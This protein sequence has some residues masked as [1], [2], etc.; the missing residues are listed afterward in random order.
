MNHEELIL[1]YFN[2]SLSKDEEAIFSNL[3]DKDSNFKI[4]FEEHD[5]MHMAY[6]INEQQ[7]LISYLKTIEQKS[8]FNFKTKLN[9]KIIGFAIVCCLVIGAFYFLNNN[10][11]NSLNIYNTYFEVYPNV[12]EPVIRGNETKTSNGFIS[13]ENARYLEAEKYFKDLLKTKTD[14]N[15][16]FYYAMSL[17]NQ[18]KTIAAQGILNS[19]KSKNHDFIPEV[20]W[21]S[22]LISIKNDDFESA[23]KELAALSS[24]NSDFKKEERIKLLNQLK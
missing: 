22:A 9:Q 21:Y 6:K 15:I 5:N 13:Y 20:Y 12:L 19:L 8:T 24:L 1:K 2:K 23:K 7:N 17:L 10:N 14:Y 18:N 11:N 3:L 16:E 4:L